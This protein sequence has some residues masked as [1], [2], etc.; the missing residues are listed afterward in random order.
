[1]AGR[2]TEVGA[3]A[4]ARLLWA[5]GT[6]ALDSD[7]QVLE[8]RSGHG[9]AASLICERLGPDGSHVGVDLIFAVNVAPLVQAP[10]AVA[11]WLR[12]AGT[13][14]LI[15]DAPAWAPTDP[16][17]VAHR[18]A[19]GLAAAG[20]VVGDLAI[21]GSTPAASVLGRSGS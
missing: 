5:V 21:G 11:G 4:S 12:P 10:A 18:L 13:L 19:A 2:L 17:E 16:E 9:V 20:Y 8:M 3:P 6:L 1:M 7:S 14:Q 15:T